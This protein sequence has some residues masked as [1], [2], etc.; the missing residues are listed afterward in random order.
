MQYSAILLMLM[1]GLRHGFD[2]D[3]IAIIDGVGVRLAPT[4]PNLAKWTGTLFAFGHGSVVTGITVTIS[5]IS[6]S[7]HFPKL[8]WDFLDWLPGILLITVGIMNL[9]MLLRSDNYGPQGIKWML[10]PRRIKNSSSPLAIVFIGILFAMV[11][12][13]N[14]QA[15]AW[16]YAATS[17]LTI[18][19]AL[20]LGLSFS[21]GMILTDT[22]DSR[23]LFSLMLRSANNESVLNYR[24]KLGWIIV[25]V[26][27]LVG[28][29]KILTH[30]LPEFSLDE[31]LLT[32]IGISF[33]IL[34]SAFYLYIIYGSTPKSK[35][36]I[37]GH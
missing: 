27:L 25:Y 16:A 1:L 33:F 6:H 4:K 14:T 36:E 11:F 22:L 24:R 5:A 9:R 21:C 12:D 18:G 35:Q 20:I 7:W 31:G 23:I 34:M 3:H 15:A 30:V 13:T 28:S 19:N 26:S 17:K 8:V 32:L 29:Y 2:P 10:V 37:N